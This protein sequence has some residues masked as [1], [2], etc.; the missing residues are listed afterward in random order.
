MTCDICPRPIEDSKVVLKGN[1]RDYTCKCK[2]EL[3]WDVLGTVASREKLREGPTRPCTC[4]N[5]RENT[6]FPRI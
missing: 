2:R 5:K 3:Q 1:H 6:G 4:S